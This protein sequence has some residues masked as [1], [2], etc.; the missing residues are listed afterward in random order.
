MAIF[1]KDPAKK[2]ERQAKAE[3]SRA[4]RDAKMRAA[5]LQMDEKARRKAQK[6]GIDVDGAIAVA[7]TFDDSAD[8]F[9]LVFPDRVDLVSRGKLGSL[10]KSG[11]G[12]ETIPASRISSVQAR[13]KGIW[14]VVEIFASGNVVEFKAD[15][16]TGP[17][18]RDQIRELLADGSPGAAAPES[19]AVDQLQRLAELHKGGILTDEEFAAKKAELLDRM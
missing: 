19:D 11:A 16:V 12:T 18:L 5:A 7:H 6:K 17:W 13:N 9:L 1:R 14:N 8:Q 2:A 4:D 3:Q 10:L 15:H